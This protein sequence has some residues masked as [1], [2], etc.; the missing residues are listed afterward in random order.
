MK[1]CVL[2]YSLVE[3]ILIAESISTLIIGLFTFSILH[4]FSRN[5]SYVSTLYISSRFFNLLANNFSQYSLMIFVF[6]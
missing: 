4:G 2:D 6:L 1:P 3:R 5:R